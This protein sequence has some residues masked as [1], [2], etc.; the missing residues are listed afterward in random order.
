MAIGAYAGIRHWLLVRGT[1]LLAMFAS[2][3]IANGVATGWKTAY[4]VAIGITSP[5]DKIVV[6][7]VLAWFLSAAGWLAVPAVCGA[8]AGIVVSMAVEGRRQ[9]PIGEALTKPG[10]PLR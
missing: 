10:E 7:P 5:G 1:A 4:D 9:R 2:L 3:Y 6:A 8:V